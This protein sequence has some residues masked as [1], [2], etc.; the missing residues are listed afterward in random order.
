MLRWLL[1]C[2]LVATPALAGPL[3]G[4]AQVR[5]GLETI[6]AAALSRDVKSVDALFADRLA[7]ISQ[8][9]RL[10]GKA[11]ALADLAGGFEAWDNSEL[12]LRE[13]G[14]GLLVTMVTTRKRPNI[15]PAR[16]RVMQLWQRD[17]GRWQLV[18]Q[19]STRIA[20]P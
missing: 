19:S 1:F 12:V 6:R 5:A 11:D 3:R 2:L 16:F 17:G 18:A 13:E 20:A 10:F 4:E 9:G 8:S 7:L 14:R 15:E